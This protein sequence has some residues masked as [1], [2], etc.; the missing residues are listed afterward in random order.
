MSRLIIPGWQG[1][2]IGHWQRFWAELDADSRVVEQD[3]W[4]FP[5][6]EDWI[7]RLD[8]AVRQA[9][10][11]MLVVHSLGC[12]LVAHYAERFPD[13]PVGRALLVAPPDID[14]LPSDHTLAGFQ[15]APLAALPFPSLLALSRNDPYITF[16]RG[17]L[18]AERWGSEFAD[19]GRAGHVNTESGHG[20]WDEGFRLADRLSGMKT[21]AAA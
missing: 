10:G 12:L 5:V 3:E 4:D 6:L 16:E 1:S 2:G 17:R 20:R 14:A 18:L 7:V 11:S 8:G 9:P 21:R 15:P 19:L 13:A